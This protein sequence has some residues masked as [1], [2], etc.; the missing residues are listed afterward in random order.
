MNR[1]HVTQC[2][3]VV[4]IMLAACRVSG[5][6]LDR[7]PAD[8]EIRYYP[9]G[10]Q[11]TATNPPY[12]AWLPV[13]GIDTYTIQYSKTD[14]FEPDHTVTVED[15]DMT[16]YIP[17]ELMEPGNWYWRYG[18]NDDG[19]SHY[20]RVRSFHIPEDAIDF[21]LVTADTLIERVPESRPRLYFTPGMVEDIRSD[22]QGRYDHLIKDVIQEAE[23]ILLMDE[24]LF[25]EPEMWDLS[26]EDYRPRYREAWRSMRPYTQRMVTSALAYL[27]TGDT[28]FAD[29]ARRRLM[30]FMT[31]DVEGASSTLW[32]TELGMDIAANAPAVFDWIYDTLSETERQICI[33]ILTKRMIQINRDVHRAMPMEA[34]PYDS[35]PGRM[36]VFAIEGGIVLA[37][38]A[39]EARDWLDYTLRLLWSTYPAWG[40]D[41]GGWHEGPW[42][43]S[44]YMRSMAR[45]ASKLDDYDIPFKNKPFVQNTGYYGLY[46]AYPGRPTGAFGDGH[47]RAL[48]DRPGVV[49]YLLARLYDNPYFRWHADK[50]NARPSGRKAVSFHDP[51]RPA[52]SPDDLP[53]SRVFYDVGLAALHSDMGDPGNNIMMLLKSNP[54][55]ALSHN[56]ASQN[57][58]VIEA[59]K[60]PLAL[61]SGARQTHFEPHHVDW[62]WHTKAHNSVLV[63][64]KGQNIREREGSSGRIIAHKE[65]G[66]Y[67]YVVGD[68]TRAY[69]DRLKRFHR[70]VLFLRPHLFVIYD[71]LQTHGDPSTFQWLLHSPTGIA[72]DVNQNLM[73]NKTNN[74]RLTT[75]FL[76][77]DSL[78]YTQHT[79]FTPQVEDSTLMRNQYHMTVSTTDAAGSNKFVT[80]LRV[81]RFDGD[82]VATPEPPSTPR[83]ELPLR[84]IGEDDEK[85]SGNVPFSGRAEEY[86]VN[87]LPNDAIRSDFEEH[88]LRAQLIPAEGGVALRIGDDL[89][90]IR[91]RNEERLTTSDAESTEDVEVRR[92]FY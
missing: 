14:S 77:P 29:E 39:E 57:A 12:F 34:R 19:K 64:N 1:C 79:G 9:E 37:H 69:G 72:V 84:M 4:T 17:V 70:H 13:D 42:Y 27:Y 3:I 8:N 89:I 91:N 62:I 18:Y 63:D 41:E 40:G 35:H 10:G 49:M 26:T 54:Y 52:K 31:W 6:G 75:R 83:R 45:I 87:E 82:P 11:T 43:W 74:V 51:G 46:A 32:P 44:G 60:E 67:A 53:H 28:R 21:P 71:E 88:F 7:E 23:E 58:F 36:V 47:H 5:N 38:E 66:D 30:H 61:S 86:L 33:E 85:A 73:V 59:H 16:V 92:N 65:K 80:L 55:G 15:I 90:L 76:T 22:T 56:H 20:S 68:A 24:P 50:L 25:Q 78:Q 2:L 48:G 81:D